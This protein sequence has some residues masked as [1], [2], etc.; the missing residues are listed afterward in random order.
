[1]IKTAKKHSIAILTATV[2]ALAT[3]AGVSQQGFIPHWEGFTNPHIVNGEKVSIAVH[4]SFDP[5]RVYTACF[6]HT[7]LDD[8]NL[9]PGDIYTV[10]MCQDLLAL[11]LPKYNKHLASCFPGLMVGDHM[12][13]ALLSFDYNAGQG[14][15]CGRSS[16]VGREFRAAANAQVDAQRAVE[17]GDPNEVERLLAVAQSHREKGC[18]NMG[19]YVRAN[20]VVLKGLQNRRYDKFWGEIEWC[21][22]DD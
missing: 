21:L 16:S 12:H 14:S 15:M 20:G 13:V 5:K 19:K 11:D 17:R 7:N 4:Q 2:I 22:R 8:P 3:G 18:Q 6:G 1:L 9:K 10:P